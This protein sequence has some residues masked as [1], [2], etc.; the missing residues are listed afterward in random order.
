[1]VKVRKEQPLDLDGSVDLDR[2]INNLRSRNPQIDIERVRKVCDLSQL[3]EEK[4]IAT[5]SVWAEGQSSFR[6][7]LDMAD[8]LMELHADE[9]G[10]VAAIIYRAVRENQLTLNHVRMEFGDVVANLIDGVLRMAS[11]SHIHLK[12]PEPVLGQDQNQREQALR[13]IV[14]LVS[15]VRV[16]LIKLA[17]RTSIMRSKSRSATGRKLGLAHEILEIYAPLAHRLGIGYLKWEL[18]DLAFRYLEPDWYKRI[19]GMLDE[20]L[21]ERQ[22]YVDRVVILLEEKLSAVGI[23]AELE[24]RAKHIYSIWRKMREKGISFSGVY[25]VHAVRI[26]VS[27]IKEC[28]S[29]LGVVHGL[30]RNISHEFDDY[31]ATPKENGYRS[32]HTAVIGPEGKMLEIQIRTNEMHSEAELGVCSHWTYK[33]VED[34]PQPEAYEE[35]LQWLRQILDWREEEDDTFNITRDLI[36]EVNLDRIYVYTPEGH[37]IDLTPDATPIDFAYRVHTEIGHKCR[38]AKVN[39]RVVPL[40][41]RFKTGDQ[42]E[43]ITGDEAVPRREWLYKHLGYITTSRARLKVQSWFGHQEQA[44]KISDGKKL[45][46]AEMDHLALEAINFDLVSKNSG[47]ESPEEMFAALGSGEIDVDN[48]VDVVAKIA[49]LEM[50]GHKA[51]I[52]PVVVPA[53]VKDGT[54]VLP[55]SGIGSL[56]SILSECCHPVP[57]DEITGVVVNK[58]MVEVHREDCIEL[59]RRDLQSKYIKIEWMNSVTKTFLA[60]IEVIAYDRSGLLYDISQVLM[61]ENSNVDSINT[62][63]KNNRVIINLKIELLSLKELMLILDK[64]EQISNIIS[65]K[66]KLV[67]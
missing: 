28:Y 57:G 51:E 5:K 58:E 3:G 21:I 27:E 7:G 55:I 41:T 39:G 2:W 30:W 62:I 38:G 40:N 67:L 14:S 22:E 37:V 13:M 49:D 8:I 34:N 23:K 59:L 64:I 10:I 9:D 16:A 47:F 4:A 63:K 46:M 45:L 35:R 12:K 6:I 26:M 36:G 33:A 43:I 52:S 25:D 65:A 24:G 19:A 54:D 61:K 48:L 56:S 29:V 44:K 17:E 42:V 60:D 11:I 53:E 50:P 20:K 15:D 31:I 18:E 1:M 66:R 32:L